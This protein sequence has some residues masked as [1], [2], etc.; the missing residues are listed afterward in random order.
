MAFTVVT[1]NMDHWKSSRRV[2]E[3]TKRAWAYIRALEVDIA[4]VQEAA[5]PLDDL[6][7]S[8]FPPPSQAERWSSGG[9]AEFGTAIAVF[10]HPAEEVS[11]GP[12]GTVPDRTNQLT[13][14]HPAAFV[15]AK[16][17]LPTQVH[18]VAVSLY[19]QL[20]GP[21]LDRETYATT[22]LHRSLSDLTPLLYQAGRQ[23]TVIGGD[24]NVSTQIERRWRDAHRVGLERIAAFGFGDCLRASAGRRTRLAGCPCDEGEHCAHVQTDYHSRSKVPWQLDYMFASQARMMDRLESCAVIDTPEVRSLSDHLPVIAKFRNLPA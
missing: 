1:W 2:T 15:A 21:L 22:T 16:I 19:G 8:V 3:H 24:L 4:L 13:Q 17:T 7:A 20:E 6:D 14:S 10:G 23:C 5:A 12:L 11:S 9:R 18:V